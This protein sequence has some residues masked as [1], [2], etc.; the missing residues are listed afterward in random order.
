MIALACSGITKRFGANVALG[1]ADFS[2]GVSEIHALVGENGAGK[3]TLL[4]I[5]SGLLRPDSGMVEVFGTP[6]NL[7]SPLDAVAL[8]IGVVHQHFLL[9]DALTVAENVALGLR[10]SPMGMRFDRRAAEE[11]V[12]ALA[13]Q[14]GLAID[15]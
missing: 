1:G 15:P 10:A 4:G 7:A 6:A 5:V 12:A 8:G 11:R 2:V 13:Q 9:A 3:S 14:T